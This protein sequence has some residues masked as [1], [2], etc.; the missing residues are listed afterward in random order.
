[1]WAAFAQV[2]GGLSAFDYGN[3][4]GQVQFWLNDGHDDAV[5]AQMPSQTGAGFATL[6]ITDCFRDGDSEGS[7]YDIAFLGAPHDTVC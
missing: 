2:V 6:P 1:M 4:G 7:R 3:P 5:V